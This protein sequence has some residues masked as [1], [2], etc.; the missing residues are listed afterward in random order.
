MTKAEKIFVIYH[1]SHISRIPILSSDLPPAIFLA[2]SAH[3]V[4]KVTSCFD[5]FGGIGELKYSQI[6]KS[7]ED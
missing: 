2:F 4:K 7:E 3:S 6:K 5:I 1:F